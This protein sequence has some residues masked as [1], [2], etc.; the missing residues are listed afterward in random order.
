MF[1]LSILVNDAHFEDFIRGDACDYTLLSG[2]LLASSQNN[3]SSRFVA[4]NPSLFL[5]DI[6]R[7]GRVRLQ[8]VSAI[9]NIG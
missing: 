1:Q 6:Q 2:Q 4:P 5:F 8:F 9:L 7:V 3:Q